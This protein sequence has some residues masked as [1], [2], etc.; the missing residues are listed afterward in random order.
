[1]WKPFCEAVTVTLGDCFI[2]QNRR[3]E[4]FC[5]NDKQKLLQNK[6]IHSMGMNTAHLNWGRV[7]FGGVCL[8]AVSVWQMSVS[9]CLLRGGGECLPKG[10]CIGGCLHGVGF[11]PTPL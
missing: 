8:E 9:W 11:C 5:I 3:K 4:I 7:L 10:V 6:R 2:F 1:M